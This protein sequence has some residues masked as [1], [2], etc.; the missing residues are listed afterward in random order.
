[1]SGL[2]Y[3]TGALI[4]AERGDMRMWALHRRALAR[5]VLPVVPAAVL[6]EA[7]RGDARMA[8]VLQGCEIEP[9][10]DLAAR[11]SG[12][13]LGACKEAVEPVDA[14]VV[15]CAVRRG[16]SIVSNN[17]RHLQALAAG[18]KRR[19]GLIDL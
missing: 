12:E 15:E 4:A 1:L 17:R 6:V 13:L 9:L 16:H 7:W 5:G 19:L 18:A 11:R 3:D 10:E 2:V 8:R 14:T